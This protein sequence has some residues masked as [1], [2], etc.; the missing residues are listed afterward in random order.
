MGP[1]VSSPLEALLERSMESPS[2]W[3]PVLSMLLHR[4]SLHSLPAC[5]HAAG[6][7]RWHTSHHTLSLS[8]RYGSQLEQQQ[9]LEWARQLAAAVEGPLRL[10]SSQIWHQGGPPDQAAL[11][12]LRL[13]ADLAAAWPRSLGSTSAAATMTAGAQLTGWRAHWKVRA[14]LPSVILGPKALISDLLACRSQVECGAGPFTCGYQRSQPVSVFCMV[15]VMWE[16]ATQW[17]AEERPEAAAL[18][19]A[20]AAALAAMARSGLAPPSTSASHLFRQPGLQTLQPPAVDLVCAIFAQ[21]RQLCAGTH[22]YYVC[23]Q[24]LPIVSVLAKD[25]R[26]TACTVQATGQARTRHP[27]ACTCWTCCSAG[28]PKVPSCQGCCVRA[29]SPCSACMLLSLMRRRLTC[30]GTGWMTKEV[31]SST[32]SC[33]GSREVSL[34]PPLKSKNCAWIVATYSSYGWLT[35]FR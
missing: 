23:H 30:Q 19:E 28:Q 17:L 18:Q 10:L 21:G 26:H 31:Q 9:Y 13:V 14:A 29:S 2:V 4:C 5:M 8:P 25:S 22:I 1:Q 33:S 7:A 34:L 6:P 3:A 15:Q 16:A 35:S 12:L 27:C 32:C 11:W 20:A 24:E